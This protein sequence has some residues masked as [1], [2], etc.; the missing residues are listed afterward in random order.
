MGIAILRYRLFDIDLLIN[1]TLAYT[2]LTA[3]LGGTYVGVVA[4]ARLLIQGR[5]A[6]GCR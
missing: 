4:A 6:A 5:A 3:V 2:I 1:R